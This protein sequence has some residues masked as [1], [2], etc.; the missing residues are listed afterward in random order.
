MRLQVEL[1]NVMGN[2]LTVHDSSAGA[3]G[4]ACFLLRVQETPSQ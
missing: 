4:S 3:A 2:S 1:N